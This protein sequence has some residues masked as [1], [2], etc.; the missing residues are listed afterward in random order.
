ML[1]LPRDWRNAYLLRNSNPQARRWASAAKKLSPREPLA[2]YVLAR[3]AAFDWRFRASDRAAR[4]RAR[5]RRREAEAKRKPTR[6]AA[7]TVGRS[8]IASGRTGAGGET[9]SA[10]C[11][12]CSRIPI[13]GQRDSRDIYLQTEQ[14]DKLEPVLGR[15]AQL[16]ADSVAIRQKLCSTGARSREDFAS[17]QKWSRKMPFPRC[18]RRPN[19][20][21]ARRGCVWTRTSSRLQRK[22]TKRRL[23]LTAA[24]PRGAADWWQSLV[25]QG[26]ETEGSRGTRQTSRARCGLS[27]PQRTT[28]IS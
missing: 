14:T 9:A 12:T 26:R 24:R 4:S 15:L 21:P 23:R 13:V 19:T 20:C 3:L 5:R 27:R 11:G 18:A 22:S 28:K 6:R 8:Q 1:P 17:A 10:R 16:D 7:R 25:K 2:A